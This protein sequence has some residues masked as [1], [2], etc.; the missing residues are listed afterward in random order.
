[1]KLESRRRFLKSAG[2]LA[3]APAAGAA[4][5]ARPARFAPAGAPRKIT[6]NLFVFE[7]TCNVYV[8]RDQSRC[9]LVDFGSDHLPYLRRPGYGIVPGRSSPRHYSAKSTQCGNLLLAG[10]FVRRIAGDAACALWTEF[11]WIVNSCLAVA[12]CWTSSY[13][14]FQDPSSGQL[15]LATRGLLPPLNES[16]RGVSGGQ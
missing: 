13:S 4:Q 15:H 5:Y 7:D 1:V 11:L 6:D 8:I 9:M 3:A 10:A 16:G 12:A 14:Q 2:R